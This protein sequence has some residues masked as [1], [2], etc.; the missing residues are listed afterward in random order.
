MSIGPGAG[1]AFV[2][3]LVFEFTPGSVIESLDLGG[4]AEIEIYRFAGLLLIGLSLLLVRKVRKR[5]VDD[6]WGVVTIA[7][8]V[9]IALGILYFITT[10]PLLLLL[11]FSLLAAITFRTMFIVLEAWSEEVRLRLQRKEF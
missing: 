11:S 7:G 4:P 2:A 6:R 8:E 9:A 3:G 1:A 10:H 5:V